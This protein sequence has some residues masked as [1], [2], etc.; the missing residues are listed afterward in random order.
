MTRKV[1]PYTT[2]QR[3]PAYWP[4]AD[5]VKQYLRNHRKYMV[6]EGRLAPSAR[7]RKRRATI[8][9]RA[10]GRNVRRKTR[11]IDEEEEGGEEDDEEGSGSNESGG[12]A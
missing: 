1:H 3:F 2:K 11:H 10:S 8:D 9:A 4:L 7:S 12:E 5:M 6:S